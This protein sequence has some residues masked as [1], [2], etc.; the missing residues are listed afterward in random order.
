L[1]ARV[2]VVAHLC[3]GFSVVSPHP[4]DVGLNGKAADLSN[5]RWS[6]DFQ[7]VTQFCDILFPA[8]LVEDVH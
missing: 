5:P 8:S 1:L 4:A 2:V 3:G 7:F 6:F